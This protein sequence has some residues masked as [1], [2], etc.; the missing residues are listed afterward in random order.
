MGLTISQGIRLLVE[1]RKQQAHLLS[2]MSKL[3]RTLTVNGKDVVTDDAKNNALAKYQEYKEMTEDI[4]ALRNEINTKNAESGVAEL[5]VKVQE[6]EKTITNL[7]HMMSTQ[8]MYE[9]SSDVVSGVGVIEKGFVEEDDIVAY[10][11][12]LE[13]EVIAIKNKMDEVNNS[14]MLELDLHHKV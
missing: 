7:S 11:K 12:N 9:S 13:T 8:Y 1:L 10:K 6:Y 5:N 2:E 3:N 4:V 14:V